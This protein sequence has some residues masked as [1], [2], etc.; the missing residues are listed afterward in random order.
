M[1]GIWWPRLSSTGAV[2]GL[3]VGGLSASAA[4]LATVLH[5]PPA[6]WPSA[7]LAQ[8]AAWSIPLALTTSVV[9]SLATPSKVPPHVARIMVRLHTPEVV[10]VD[11]RV[12][13][14]A[15]RAEA[16]ADRSGADRTSP[17]A[18]R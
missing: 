6:G 12:A 2:A 4:V 14:T 15:R 9:V 10:D 16:T 5:L 8:P 7:L 13:P 17:P 18:R 3:L 11:R 1:L